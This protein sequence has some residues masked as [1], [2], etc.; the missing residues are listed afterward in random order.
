VIGVGVVVQLVQY[1]ICNL[2]RCY[3]AALQ[4]CLQLCVLV[5]VVFVVVAARC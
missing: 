1:I 4:C 2:D 3:R 5:F